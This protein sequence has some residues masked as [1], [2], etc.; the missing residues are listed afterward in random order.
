MTGVI[1]QEDK[2]RTEQAV[3]CSGPFPRF[4]V[5]AGGLAGTALLLQC[6]LWPLPKAHPALGQVS[7]AT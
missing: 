7:I 4:S 2:D 5:P 1:R 6:A 3:H